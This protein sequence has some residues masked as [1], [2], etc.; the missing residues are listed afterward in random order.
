MTDETELRAAIED[1]NL[2]WRKRLAT[3]EKLDMA[4][5]EYLLAFEEF[6]KANR[7]VMDLKLETKTEA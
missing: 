5:R 1:A 3:K 7:R 2:K 4:E 6:N